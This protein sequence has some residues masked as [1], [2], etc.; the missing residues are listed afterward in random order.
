MRKICLTSSASSCFNITVEQTKMKRGDSQNFSLEQHL[1]AVKD[2][3]IHMAIAPKSMWCWLSS[4]PT[5]WCIDWLFLRHRPSPKH[6]SSV[7]HR[8]ALCRTLEVKFIQVYFLPFPA[9]P[10]IWLCEQSINSCLFFLFLYLTITFLK[11][12]N[13]K[14]PMMTL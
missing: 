3:L 7:L 1:D 9:K 14:Y 5:H 13:G 12:Y 8:S 2:F 10:I 4:P 6:K 11:V